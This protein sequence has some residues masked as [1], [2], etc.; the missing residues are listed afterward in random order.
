MAEE[1]SPPQNA[2]SSNHLGVVYSKKAEPGAEKREI[3]RGEGLKSSSSYALRVWMPGLVVSLHY[4]MLSQT[5]TGS[6][7][8]L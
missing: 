7:C 1:K 2:R 5:Y 3:L 4:P 8:V 6:V